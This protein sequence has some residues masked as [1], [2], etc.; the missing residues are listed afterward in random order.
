MTLHVK[1]PW[2]MIW[3]EYADNLIAQIKDDLPPKHEL[4]D[5]KLFA[6]IKWDHRPIYIV[7]DDT[8]G[9]R[10]LMNFEKMKPW[11]KTKFKA[12]QITVFKDEEE[13]AQ[14]IERDHVTECAKHN[15]DGTLKD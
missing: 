3:I 5:H 4:Q 11:N 10:I 7:D 9:G 8:T 12:P 13:V 6:G 1:W 2:E 14:M 15:H